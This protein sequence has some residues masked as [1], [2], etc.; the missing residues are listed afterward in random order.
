MEQYE[1]F[2][3]R[4]VLVTIFILC[5]LIL[6]LTCTFLRLSAYE[7]SSN[8]FIVNN[9][10]NQLLVD[11][12]F[13]G[14]TSDCP[15][16]YSSIKIGKTPHIKPGWDCTFKGQSFN[17]RGIE[18]Y[19]G[20]Y[21]DKQI[22][23]TCKYISEYEPIDIYSWRG[24]KFCGK[25][26]SYNYFTMKKVSN[27]NT[28]INSKKNVCIQGYKSCGIVDTFNNL[29]CIK[30]SEKCPINKL[31]V[32]NNGANLYNNETEKKLDFPLSKEGTYTFNKSLII[33]YSNENN[34]SFTSI[35]DNNFII[36]EIFIVDGEVCAN[37][38]EKS[39]S[40]NRA[41]KLFKDYEYYNMCNTI[42]GDL[43]F[44][45]NPIYTQIDSDFGKNV[46]K[47]YPLYSY[48]LL[49]LFPEFIYSD[50]MRFHLY[51]GP[52]IGLNSNQEIC[53]VN[54]QELND[55]YN[56]D[57]NSTSTID[58]G[59]YAIVLCTIF[60][61]VLLFIAFPFSY[62]KRKTEDEEDFFFQC[63]SIMALIYL[64]LVILLLIVCISF[65]SLTSNK[66]TSW[67]LFNSFTKDDNTTSNSQSNVFKCTDAY[68]G[69]I[70]I[71]LAK[72]I[73]KFYI[74]YCLVFVIISLLGLFPFKI[75]RK[76]INLHCIELSKR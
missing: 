53:K 4:S 70:L 36:S 66:L 61:I 58:S 74:N 41:Y 48:N 44:N 62:L 24:V 9:W 26:L 46:Y 47:D 37:P 52:Y 54:M 69:S 16:G 67:K 25:Y 43:S 34:T 33:S 68:T 20:L 60:I 50:T 57:N 75:Y 15:T 29:L 76:Y 10:R 49:P 2:V 32:V 42:A 7:I 21:E 5:I 8:N 71:V 14:V 22:D 11:I 72:F 35:K 59:Y 18:N 12:L 23:R 30:A 51:T 1:I 38:M 56:V 6:F 28:Q 73:Y 27:N 63:K 19:Y 17:K 64:T 3:T 55:N 39:I 65:Y 13:V 45:I 31:K 40:K